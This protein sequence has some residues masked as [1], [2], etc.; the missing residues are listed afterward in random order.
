MTYETLIIDA[1]YEICKD[2]PY[3]IRKKGTDK[4]VNETRHSMGY[5][6]CSL[7][8][9]VRLKHTIVAKQWIIND[10]PEHKTQVDHI[11]HDRTDNH[12]DNLRWVTPSENM[13]NRS[14]T[15]GVIYEIY[16]EIPSDDEE[17]DIIKVTTYG[18]Y[19]FNNLYFNRSDHCFYLNNG[20]SYR[21]LH[22]NRDKNNNEFV[23]VK[24][25]LASPSTP[26]R[27]I[28]YKTFKRRYHISD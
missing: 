25:A 7:S 17:A 9:K 24:D 2:F 12:T 28:Y 6:Q 1:D 18:K 13:F 4:I 3:V 5:V 10:D 11:N 14:S 15:R 8:G 19:T 27:K 26:N 23:Y 22:V 16:D 21:K 20:V